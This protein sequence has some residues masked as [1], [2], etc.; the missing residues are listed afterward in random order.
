MASVDVST[1]VVIDRPRDQ[2]ARYAADPDNVA[3]WYAN[4]RSVVWKTDRPAVLGSQVAFVAHFLGRRLEYTYE[5]VE[6]IPG[7]KLV[8]RT[9]LGPFPME[10]T[11]TWEAITESSTLM[12]LRNRGRPAGFS[13]LMAPLLAFMVRRATRKDLALLKRLL[14]DEPAEPDPS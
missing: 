12:T 6:R 10:T 5:I 9:A 7:E 3:E 4:I 11:Y 2:V 8:M 14:E 13:A 1:E